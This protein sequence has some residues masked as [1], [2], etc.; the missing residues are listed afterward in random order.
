MFRDTSGGADF[1]ASAT[2]CKSRT[3]R[4][5]VDVNEKA[6]LQQEIRAAHNICDDDGYPDYE[7]QDYQISN[8]EHEIRHLEEEG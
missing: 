3:R 2:G 8:L 4:V 5:E 1:R 6:I 7:E